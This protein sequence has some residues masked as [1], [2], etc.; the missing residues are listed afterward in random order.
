[1]TGKEDKHWNMT[2]VAS[3]YTINLFPTEII[4]RMNSKGDKSNKFIYSI[5]MMVCLLN[6][7]F[8]T[9]FLV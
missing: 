5:V 6:L 8:K 2:V 9:L 3:L 7:H 1:M 4:L